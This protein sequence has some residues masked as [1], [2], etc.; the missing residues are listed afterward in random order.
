MAEKQ[1]EKIIDVIQVGTDEDVSV[2]AGFATI[3][4][5]TGSMMAEGHSIADNLLVSYGVKEVKMRAC[6]DDLIGASVEV[7]FRY[8]SRNNEVA[9]RL[10]RDLLKDGWVVKD[11]TEFGM[12]QED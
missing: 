7:S 1:V 9:V 12:E 11:E 4:N 8:E 6:H 3:I 10:L 2:V 5:K